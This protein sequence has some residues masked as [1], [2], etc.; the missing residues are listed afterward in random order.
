MLFKCIFA[1]IS[2]PVEEEMEDF[3][4]VILLL[5]YELYKKIWTVLYNRLN[6]SKSNILTMTSVVLMSVFKTLSFA[7]LILPIII[8]A[9][10]VYCFIT[11]L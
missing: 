1:I 6:L 10:I 9:V 7:I 4:R 3:T 11:F 8:I 5:F 2:P